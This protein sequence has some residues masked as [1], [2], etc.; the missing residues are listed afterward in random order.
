MRTSPDGGSLAVM[1][2]TRRRLWLFAPAD[3]SAG[4]DT[5]LAP[6]T[7]FS[8]SAAPIAGREFVETAYLTAGCWDAE[9]AR[10]AVASSLG[11]VFVLTR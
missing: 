7:C 5:V 10:F 11:Q 3:A 4:M 8:A 1:D 9:G 2:T 6:P